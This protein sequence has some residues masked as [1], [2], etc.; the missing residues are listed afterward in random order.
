[1]QFITGYDS[2]EEELATS[3]DDPSDD[4][5]PAELFDRYSKVP[6]RRG[7][8]G[9]RTSF[10]YIP[11]HPT[12][13]QIN[14]FELVLD[15][16]WDSTRCQDPQ[17]RR[18]GSVSPTKLEY[19]HISL[20]G[21]FPEQE[22]PRPSITLPKQ[23]KFSGL[24]LLPDASHSKMFVALMTKDPTIRALIEWAN[25]TIQRRDLPPYDVKM[26]H[27]SIG[28]ILLGGPDRHTCEI[29]EGV[30]LFEFEQEIKLGDVVRTKGMRNVILK[31]VNSGSV[32][33]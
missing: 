6:L 22:V 29:L 24:R 19:F 12:V 30:E 18:I 7:Y 14:E 16:V 25:E 4:Q 2:N 8:D 20:S 3:E 9:Q 33:G 10:L 11:V 17:D 1:M 31:P 23:I 5:V 32:P 27:V 21:N 26:A 13:E 28:T 15:H